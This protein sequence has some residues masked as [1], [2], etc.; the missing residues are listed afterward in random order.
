MA[1]KKKSK[2]GTEQ[3]LKAKVKTLK[4]NLADAK[5]KRDKWKKRAR[6]AETEVAD[7]RQG[8]KQAEKTAGKPAGKTVKTL[9]VNASDGTSAA[10]APTRSALPTPDESWTLAAL[11]DEARRRGVTGLSGKPKADVLAA[12]RT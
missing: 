4:A 3:Q 8:R 2:A 1:K 9:P 7:L 10:S 5:A 12:L 6:A 11:R